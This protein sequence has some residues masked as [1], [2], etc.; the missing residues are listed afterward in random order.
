MLSTRTPGLGEHGMDGRVA[1]VQLAYV[2]G[3]TDDNPLLHP[4]TPTCAGC[5]WPYGHIPEAIWPLE[6]VDTED[7]VT[8]VGWGQCEGSV[9][10]VRGQC[11]GSVRAVRGQCEGSVRA[12]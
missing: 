7:A 8:T 10:A 2:T 9:R 4:P 5:V 12:V 6:F 1:P 3:V 11:E